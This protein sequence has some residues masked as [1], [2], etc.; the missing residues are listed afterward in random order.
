MSSVP[1]FSVD[2]VLSNPAHSDWLKDAL[3]AAL[4]RDPLD[5][6]IDASLLA[7][8]LLSRSCSHPGCSAPPH[9]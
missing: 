1:D 8:I 5:A 2:A 6:A 7:Q 9:S 4:A 3:R